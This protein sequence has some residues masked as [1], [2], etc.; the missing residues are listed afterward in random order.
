MYFF[1]LG[2]HKTSS[3]YLAKCIFD[4]VSKNCVLSNKV[5][6]IEG[7][8]ILSYSI[9][10]VLKLIRGIDKNQ[11]NFEQNVIKAYIPTKHLLNSPFLQ[12]Q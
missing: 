8:E 3:I 11:N 12:L 10:G 7:L 2:H 9:T 5:H 6:H 1:V 4:G